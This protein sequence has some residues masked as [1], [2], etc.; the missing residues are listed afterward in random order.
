MKLKYIFWFISAM[1]TIEGMIQTAIDGLEQQ[2]PVR[3]VCTI[4]FKFL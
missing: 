1:T 2:Q 4:G 3:K